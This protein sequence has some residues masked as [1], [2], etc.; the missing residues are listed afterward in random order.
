[1]SKTDAKVQKKNN[2]TETALKKYVVNGSPYGGGDVGKTL[3]VK[4][5]FFC[6]FAV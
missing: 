4:W 1:L 6:K 2:T 3:W 5:R